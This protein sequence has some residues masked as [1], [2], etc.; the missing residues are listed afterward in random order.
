VPDG[1]DVSLSDL[2]G[3]RDTLLVYHFMYGTNWDEG[4]PSCSMWLDGL[5]GVAAHIRQNMAFAVVAR[6]EPA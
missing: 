6:A 2:F 3:E 5:N 1:A 4:C